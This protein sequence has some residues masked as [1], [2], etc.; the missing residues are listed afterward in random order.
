[1]PPDH[2]QEELMRDFIPNFRDQQQQLARLDVER[3]MHDAFGAV[4]SDRHADLLAA[5]PIATVE[6]WRLGDDDFIQHQHDC[7]GVRPKPAF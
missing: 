6:R 3:A 1:M 5:S 4:A 7:V 2:F